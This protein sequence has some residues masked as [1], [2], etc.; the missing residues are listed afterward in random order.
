MTAPNPHHDGGCMCGAIRYR[1]HG[2]FT[3]SAHCHCRSCQRAVGAGFATYSA[4]APDNFEILQGEMAIYHSSPGV[5]RG[6]CGTCG[7]S[8]SYAGDDWTDY[9]ILS[10]TLDD[11]S[12]ARPTTNVYVSEKQPWVVLDERLRAYPKFP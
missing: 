8:L 6:F 3:Y 2:P 11:P 9:A 12:A 4:V 1:L 10:A 7:T 5:R